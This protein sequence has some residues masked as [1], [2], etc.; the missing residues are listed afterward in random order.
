[1]KC[2]K[3]NIENSIKN[4]SFIE[5]I[6]NKYNYNNDRFSGEDMDE[7]IKGDDV[8]KSNDSDDIKKSIKSGE[9]DVDK[10]FEYIFNC[11]QKETKN[12]N[13]YVYIIGSKNVDINDIS[14]LK[15]KYKNIDKKMNIFIINKVDM[16]L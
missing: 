1:L 16:N 6:N 14:R 12:L 7:S 4:I 13:K 5:K 8:K 3:Q 10:S 11:K 15:E 2:E 9:K